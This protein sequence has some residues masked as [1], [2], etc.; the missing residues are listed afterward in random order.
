MRWDEDCCELD[1]IKYYMILTVCNVNRM[2]M[3]FSW[4]VQKKRENF[5]LSI[6]YLLVFAKACNCMIANKRKGDKEHMV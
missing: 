1:I 6:Y 3:K 2:K 5:K 4:L